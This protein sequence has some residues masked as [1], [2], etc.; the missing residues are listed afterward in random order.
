M[1]EHPRDKRIQYI[2]DGHL[3]I[4]QG[5]ETNPKSVTA[6]ISEFFPKF[7]PEKAA[8]NVIK[9]RAYISGQSK[10]SGMTKEE[11][12]AKWKR[13]GQNGTRMHKKIENHII[14]HFKVDEKERLENEIAELRL[15]LSRKESR[16]AELQDT[17]PLL[18]FEQ[19]TLEDKPKE[20]LLLTG[21][22]DHSEPTPLENAPGDHTEPTSESDVSLALIPYE[23]DQLSPAE[24]VADA[25]VTGQFLSFWS[26]LESSFPDC[27]PYRTEW[28]IY[29][30][31][32]G[33]AGC[34]DFAAIDKYGDLILFDWK[35]TE[36]LK[37]EN[38]W[39]KGLGIFSHLDN[40]NFVKYTLQL[41]TY[42]YILERRYGLHVKQMFLVILHEDNENWMLH[43]VERKEK[44]MQALWSVTSP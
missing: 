4:V 23:A 28:K 44:E 29:D 16:L 41:N 15:I 27:K 10:Y 19:L 26:D 5:M 30:E 43:E 7:D 14:E 36:N 32:R 40:C 21:P 6:V 39:E 38:K 13:A 11:I 42:R 2:D 34:I 33:I 20:T 12:M 35:R 18:E 25:R 9:G 24:V 8:D 1:G 22:L 3:Y 31:E 17:S 37:M